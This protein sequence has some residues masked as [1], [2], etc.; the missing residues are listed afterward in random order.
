MDD[1]KGI[2]TI[3]NVGMS[4]LDYY[5]EYDINKD[6]LYKCPIEELPED[7]EQHEVTGQMSTSNWT[8]WDL[9]YT[10]KLTGKTYY[11]FRD[12]IND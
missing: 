6:K 8:A 12:M 10:S 7:I 4:L 11:P 2:I 5:Y 3:H 1:T 9:A